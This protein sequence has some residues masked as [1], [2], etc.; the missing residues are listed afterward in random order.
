MEP[1]SSVNGRYG[2]ERGS[3]LTLQVATLCIHPLATSARLCNYV[4]CLSYD[5]SSTAPAEH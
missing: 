4:A 1:K 5:T 3:D 2:P